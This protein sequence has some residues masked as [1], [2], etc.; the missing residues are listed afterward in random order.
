LPTNT[1]KG[2]SEAKQQRIFDAALNE[3]SERSFSEAK[4][5]NIIKD[6]KIPR[7]SFYQY[8]EDKLDL[9]KYIFEKFGEKKIEYMGELVYNP[10][11][12]PFLELIKDLYKLGLRYAINNPKGVKMAMYLMLSQDIVF[13]EILGKGLK[14]AKQFYEGYIESDKRL[15]R[16]NPEVDTEV[17]SKITM[18]LIT[19]ISFDEMKSGNGD[20]DFDHMVDKFNK[21]IYI[22]EKGI[23]IGD[24]NV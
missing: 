23:L 5:S 2:L 8:F 11:E 12:I 6:A 14:Q 1:F 10:E 20:L 16:I 15:G 9:Y 7:G 19:N 13:E 21:T 17:L 24:K 4:L 18:D 3:F 22:L